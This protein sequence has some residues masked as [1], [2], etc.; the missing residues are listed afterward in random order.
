MTNKTDVLS[1][2]DRQLRALRTIR[3]AVENQTLD[4]SYATM[5][6]LLKHPIEF[7]ALIKDRPLR[8]LIVVAREL[9]IKNY[10]R[11][12]KIKLKEQVYERI[13]QG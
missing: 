10:G 9:G 13:R 12:T 7:K 8:D 6:H 3:Y 2:I 11:L 4:M 5:L 1:A